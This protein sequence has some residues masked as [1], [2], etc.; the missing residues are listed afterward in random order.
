MDKKRSKEEIEEEIRLLK[1][2]FELHASLQIIKNDKRFVKHIDAILDRISELQ[3][4]L[5]E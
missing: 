2:A 5:N 1:M 4:E 3:K